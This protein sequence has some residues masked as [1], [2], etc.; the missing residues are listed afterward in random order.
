[1][2]IDHAALT[3]QIDGFTDLTQDQ[4]AKASLV[5]AGNSVDAE[6]ASIFLQMLGLHS[7]K[8]NPT[9]DDRRGSTMTLPAGKEP[10]PES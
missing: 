5:V 10:L 9:D 3:D 7:G 8:S 1:M 2:A 4:V 6:E